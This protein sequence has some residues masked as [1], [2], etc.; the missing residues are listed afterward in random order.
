M[1][2]RRVTLLAALAATVIAA[3]L[4]AALPRPA[5]AAPSF[6]DKQ[7]Q[8]NVLLLQ[9]YINTQAQKDGFTYPAVAEVK[10]GGALEAPVWPGNPWTGKTMAPGTSRGTYTYRLKADGTG[11][12]LVGHMSTGDYKLT[13]G[14]PAWLKTERD[15]AGKAG[16]ALLQGYV[17]AWRASHGGAPP[18]EADLAASGAVGLQPGVPVWPQNPWTHAPMAQGTGNGDFAYTVSGASYTLKVH[19]AAAKDWVL[20]SR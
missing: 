9:G 2:V 7:V 10:K 6:V 12:T 15:D 16:L 17:E 19:L 14:V 11:Y 20:E 5:A 4:A 18:A 1:P 3:G 13:G 8:M